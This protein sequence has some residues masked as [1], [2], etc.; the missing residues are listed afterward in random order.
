MQA[1]HIWGDERRVTEAAVKIASA[2][3][4]SP[5]DPK[6]TARPISALRADAGTTI[7]PAGIGVDQEIGRAHV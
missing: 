4:S 5:S 7:T 3:I 6:T 2:R 1:T